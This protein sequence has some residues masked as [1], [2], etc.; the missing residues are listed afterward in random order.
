MTV[1]IQD[2]AIIIDEGSRQVFNTNDK[3]F[4]VVQP[5]NG[6]T[7]QIAYL[8]KANVGLD[9]NDY[10]PLGNVNPVC[11]QAIGGVKFT[12]N[13]GSAKAGFAFNR[14]HT[15]MGGTMVWVMDGEPGFTNELGSNSGCRQIVAYWIEIVNGQVRLRRR[16]AFDGTP[17]QYG[18]YAH[19]LQYKLKCG[20]WV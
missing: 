18:V 7:Q 4:H 9:I 16:A 12:L 2:G 20:V 8:T 19:T 13:A 3:L 17:L 5:C 11:N 10:I 6:Q 15:Y 14:W 1:S